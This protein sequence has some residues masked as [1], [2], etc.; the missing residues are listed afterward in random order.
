MILA[1]DAGNSRI[2][3]GL[4][5]DIDWIASGRA[6]DVA[7]LATAW[8][9]LPAP[10]RIMIVNV[11]GE[12]VR[13]GLLGAV[14]HWRVP[15]TWVNSSIL[16]FGV[17]NSYENP[18]Q[19]G[20]DRWAALIGARHRLRDACLVVN[21]GTALTIDALSDDGVFIGGII[22]P[23]YTLMRQALA[24]N[25]AAL[26]LQSGEFAHFPL[27]TGDAI[28]SGAVQAM[29]GAVQQMAQEASIVWGRK[30]VCILSG[31]DAAT[32]RPHLNLK[33]KLVDNLVLEGLLVLGRT[34]VSP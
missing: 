3:W 30:P 29:A 12:R 17:R 4:H 19:L 28:A 26:A 20:A 6:G 14:A 24:V 1:I 31:G 16:A 13:A 18:G 27:N 7:E 25:T 15:P 11:A 10:E 33:L 2:K 21:A 8:A 32:L 23:G 22:V 9:A 5:N 34:P